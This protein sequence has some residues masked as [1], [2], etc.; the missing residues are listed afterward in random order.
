MA[1]SVLLLILLAT[2]NVLLV[3]LSVPDT[4]APA[5]RTSSVTGD[6]RLHQFTSS[7]LGNT[8]T[9]RVLLPPGYDDERNKDRRYPVLYL[10][11]GQN[12]FDAATSIFNPIEWQV[13]E[14]ADRLVRLK[15]IVPLIVVGVD[16]PGKR[17][18]PKEYLPYADRFL[19]PPEPAPEGK[20][21]PDFLVSE[22]IPFI[23]KRYRTKP[24][25]ALP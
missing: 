11:D 1:G 12:L 10:N 21:Y 5:A 7:I 3:R 23:N 4:R 22:L 14:S 19:S 15:K 9:I 24:L 18:R 8:R 16:N 13:D 6:L 25:A 20:K 17:L 2:H